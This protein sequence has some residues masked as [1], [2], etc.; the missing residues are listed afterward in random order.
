MLFQPSIAVT[1]KPTAVIVM[2]D[3]IKNVDVV[4]NKI[5]V[6]TVFIEPSTSIVCLI[7]LSLIQ[8]KHLF[9]VEVVDAVSA[10]ERHIDIAD[11]R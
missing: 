10:H 8:G 5:V 9:T 11:E 7:R 2:D 6:V 1:V 4:T 3:I